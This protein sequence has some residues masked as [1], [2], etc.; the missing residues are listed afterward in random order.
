[1]TTISDFQT[2]KEL[3]IFAKKR[4]AELDIDN[5]SFGIC[6]NIKKL[7]VFENA[8][9][10]MGF[11]PFNSEIDLTELYKDSSK[12]WLLPSVNL[13]TKEMFVHP[14]VYDDILVENKYRVAEPIN[15]HISNLEII[16]IVITPALM[17]DK[18]GYRLGYGAGFYDRFLPKLDSNCIKILPVPEEF[19]IDKLPCDEFDIPVDFVVTEKSAYKIT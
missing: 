1:M 8:K 16:D 15:K 19:F 9:N 6:K 4:R 14:Y 18:C 5:I 13:S 7:S 10:I 2:K 17:A 12:I 3:R 11:Y